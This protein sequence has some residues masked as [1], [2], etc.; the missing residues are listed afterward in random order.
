MRIQ[1]AS[2]RESNS[3]HHFHTSWGITDIWCKSVLRCGQIHQRTL[4]S[5]EKGDLTWVENL[6]T[7]STCG[8]ESQSTQDKV[9][10]RP[11]PSLLPRSLVIAPPTKGSQ[12]HLF[13]TFN[14]S[15]GREN[16]LLSSTN[17]KSS[18]ETL[19]KE[20]Y[21]TQKLTCSTFGH[22]SSEKLR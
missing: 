9:G 11:E 4:A 7:Q 12:P 13:L 14:P 8:F 1:C 18:N 10:G 15:L 16:A 20:E 6:Q 17:I 21:S 5:W 3:T 19:I 22:T 2:C